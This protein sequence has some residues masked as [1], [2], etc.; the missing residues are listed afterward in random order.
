MNTAWTMPK[1]ISIAPPALVKEK[2]PR[3]RPSSAW[4]TK[5][6]CVWVRHFSNV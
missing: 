4:L 6:H 2:P 3:N 1:L 5:R